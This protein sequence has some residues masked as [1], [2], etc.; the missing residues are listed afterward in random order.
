MTAKIQYLIYIFIYVIFKSKK[1]CAANMSANKEL[2][3][4]QHPH[5]EE[6]YSI[7]LEMFGTTPSEPAKKAANLFKKGD[8]VK[9]LE[10]G[11]GQGR[12][13]FFLA[14]NGF[15]VSVLDY[16]ENGIQAINNKA[17]AKGLDDKITALQHDVRNILPFDDHTFDGCFSHMLFNMALTAK[18]L[19]FLHDE[20]MRVLK[21][22]GLNIYTARNNND[23]HYQKGVHIDDDIYEVNGF[24]LH[25]ISEEKVRSLAKNYDIVNIEEFEEDELPKKLFKVTLR[26]RRT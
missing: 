11:G 9:I 12:D 7:Y 1:E 5:W 21:P 19:K 4:K 8:A 18:E 16:S 26:K 23:P 25:F 10:L 14:Q 22:G 13:T 24:V 17:K 2:L 20:I 6:M 3:D 15:I